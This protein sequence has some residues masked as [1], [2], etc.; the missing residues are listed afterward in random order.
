MVLDNKEDVDGRE[1][2]QPNILT[3]S[4]HGAPSIRLKEMAD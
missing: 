4:I 3:T 1:T 2:I